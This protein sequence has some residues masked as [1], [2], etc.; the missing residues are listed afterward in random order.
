MGASAEM[1]FG[2][3][4]E[5]M[6]DIICG[7]AS[8]VTIKLIPGDVIPTC[9]QDPGK[10]YFG[11]RKGNGIVF[12]VGEFKIRLTCEEVNHFPK[13]WPRDSLVRIISYE[14][15]DLQVTF[16]RSREEGGRIWKEIRAFFFMEA[17]DA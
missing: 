10:M 13:R 2:D 7:G 17:K 16:E 9:T 6:S 15:N 8:V 5:A 14:G 1:K 12:G 3:Y 11:R 4:R